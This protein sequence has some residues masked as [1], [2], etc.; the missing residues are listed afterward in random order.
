MNVQGQSR[1]GSVL[2]SKG[3]DLA[4]HAPSLV[5]GPFHQRRGA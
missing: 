3:G 5:S 1:L 2:T 4:K